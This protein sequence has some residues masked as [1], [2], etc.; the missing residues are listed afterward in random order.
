MSDEIIT[1][2]GVKMGLWNGGKIGELQKEL[3]R[4]RQSLKEAG[5]VDKLVATQMPHR[6]QLPEDLRSFNAYPIWG[7][8][9]EENCLCGARAN[10]IV[11]TTDVRQFSMVEHH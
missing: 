10:R 2:S 5:G 7:C 3:T 8:D 9:K 1:Q 11:S 4:I 6:D